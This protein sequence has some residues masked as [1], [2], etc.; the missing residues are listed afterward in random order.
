[1]P[2]QQAWASDRAKFVIDTLTAT[3]R[4]GL[5][6]TNVKRSTTRCGLEAADTSSKGVAVIRLLMIVDIPPAGGLAAVTNVGRLPPPTGR[7]Y[8]RNRPDEPSVASDLLETGRSPYT[9]C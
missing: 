6:F 7:I 2:A 9:G 1:M 8:D 4:A 3:I 5:R